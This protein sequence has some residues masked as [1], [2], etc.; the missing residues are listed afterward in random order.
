MDP[1]AYPTT[2]NTRRVFAFIVVVAVHI[3]LGY[4]INA[5]LTDVIMDKVLGNLQTVEIAAPTEEEE[6]P[7][8]PP[9]KMETP[10]PFVPPPEISIEIAPTETTTAI[11]VVTQTRPVEAPPP[12]AVRKIPRTAPGYD[13]RKQYTLPEYPPSE[14]RAGHEGTVYLDLF[15]QVDGRIGDVRVKTSSGFPRLDEAA[16][17]HVKRTYRL[18]PAMEDGKP[19]ADWVTLPV[20]FRIDNK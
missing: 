13:K 16:V 17:S 10:P 4:G 7:P 2:N 8:P 5:G 15:V 14:L 1:G 6:K 20:V 3:I 19:V 9:P 18:S 12:V 11:Q